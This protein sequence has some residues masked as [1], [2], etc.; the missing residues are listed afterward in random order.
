MEPWTIFKALSVFLLGTILLYFA[1]YQFVVRRW[2]IEHQGEIFREQVLNMGNPDW[3]S[4][5]MI[6]RWMKVCLA[7]IAVIFHVGL[8]SWV[9]AGFTLLVKAV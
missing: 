3:N 4:G 1:F 7:V 6:P 2:V 8:W 9:V 5:L